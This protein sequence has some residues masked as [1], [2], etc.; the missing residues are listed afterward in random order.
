MSHADQVQVRVRCDSVWPVHVADHVRT[1]G[2]Q[3]LQSKYTEIRLRARLPARG[4]R[5]RVAC[6]FFIIKKKKTPVDWQKTRLKPS[7]R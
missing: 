2:G 3:L 5:A 6:L 1:S 4:R 7:S